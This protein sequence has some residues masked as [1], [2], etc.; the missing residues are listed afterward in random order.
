MNVNDQTVLM[1]GLFFI[2]VISLI[3]GLEA[4]TGKDDEE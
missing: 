1:I 3:M 2:V 4:M